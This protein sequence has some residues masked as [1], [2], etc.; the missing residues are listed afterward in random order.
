[1]RNYSIHKSRGRAFYQ[2]YNCKY[3]LFYYMI[4]YLG[5]PVADILIVFL[6]ITYNRTEQSI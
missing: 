6:L 5:L 1:M 4:Q 3:A 2:H